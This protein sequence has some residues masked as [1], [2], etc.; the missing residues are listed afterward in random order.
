MIKSLKSLC[1]CHGVSGSCTSKSCVKIPSS[2]REIGTALKK[3][4]YDAKKVEP[5]NDKRTGLRLQAAEGESHPTKHDLIYMENSPNFCDADNSLGT[6]GIS[7]RICSKNA[8][9][10]NSC[11]SLCCGRG[12]NTQRLKKD[13]QCQCKFKWCCYVDCKKCTS[14]TWVTS[15]K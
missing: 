12:Y 11:A 3:M 2:L 1:K 13:T 14:E 8:T 6:R 5:A 10:E 9:E 15:C 4:Y 7:G